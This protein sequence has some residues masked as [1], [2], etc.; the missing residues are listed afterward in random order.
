M[1]Y[2][3]FGVSDYSGFCSRCSVAQLT[4]SGQLA[5][6]YNCKT[7]NTVSKKN[8][9]SHDLQRQELVF[10]PWTEAD[11]AVVGGLQHG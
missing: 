6:G 1:R 10:L 11:A 8:E 4:S 3:I 7:Q 5:V 9:Q 2:Y